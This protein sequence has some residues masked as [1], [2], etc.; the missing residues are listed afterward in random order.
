MSF[1]SL[2]MMS[3]SKGLA[4]AG[5]NPKTLY[6]LQNHIYK[7]FARG[8]STEWLTMG[9]N[10]ACLCSTD[11]SRAPAPEPLLA[12]PLLLSSG[13]HRNRL[14]TRT[15]T[16]TSG[17]HYRPRPSTHGRNDISLEFLGEEFQIHTRL[18]K[19]ALGYSGTW[20]S[21]MNFWEIAELV[22]YT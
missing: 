3:F 12:P 20:E 11:S 4:N 22:H 15:Y 21:R 8:W 9:S 18:L 7:L 13:S 6:K 19:F 2:S 5:T 17:L 10:P 1:E 16:C 14:F